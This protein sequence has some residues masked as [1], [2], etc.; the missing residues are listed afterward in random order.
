M[1]IGKLDRP[2]VAPFRP[3]LFASLS[4]ALLFA[5]CAGARAQAQPPQTGSSLRLAQAE[6]SRPGMEAR[7]ERFQ[8]LAPARGYLEAHDHVQ[9]PLGLL[10]GPV[11]VKV[12]QGSG[13]VFVSLPDNRRIDEAV[14]GPPD[15]PRAYG[16]TPL[17]NGLPP[18][19]RG[20]RQSASGASGAGYS[21]ATAE[22]G[23]PYTAVEQKSP[24][25]DK[26]IV[27]ADGRLQL[28]AVDATATDAAR[29]DDS[30]KFEASWKDR[31]GST[32]SVRC[33]KM[34]ASHGVEYPTFGGVVTNHLMRTA[35]L[36]SAPP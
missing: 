15:L 26:H 13:G 12:A 19:V 20:L 18:F 23:N 6:T 33:C 22:T 10:G 1:G 34:L 36:A 25:G 28:E 2:N 14:F 4:A 30:V 27:M 17:I 16:G 9:K 8:K 31:A 7:V 32:Y 35:S 5:G 24:F 29:S 21:A 3:F 11:T